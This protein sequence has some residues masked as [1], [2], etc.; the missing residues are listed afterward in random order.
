M[1]DSAEVLKEE[2]PLSIPKSFSFVPAKL[3]DNPALMAVNPDYLGS[4]LNLPLIERER[5]LAGNW[6]I[7]PAAGLVFNRSWFD[8]CDAVPAGGDCVRFWD[9]AASVKKLKGGDPDSTA[10]VRMRKVDGVFYIDDVVT[11]QEAPATAER[12]I[13]ARCVQD[14]NDC[15]YTGTRY[16]A[17]WE[18]E[19]SAGARYN[20]YH[21]T[22]VLAGIRTRGI[23]SREDKVSRAGA[24]STQAE[25]RN[26]KILK[27]PW[28]EQL[29]RELHQ[30]PDGAHDDVPDA[31]AG[32]F[33]EVNSIQPFRLNQY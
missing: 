19:P 22:T 29:L 30:F 17:A 15:K 20:S 27:A 6:K 4:M 5:L 16:Q 13:I 21:L 11:M 12:K 33:N 32:A 24:M 8:L 2:Y 7:R 18:I 23:T 31:C 26:I 1:A 25:V 28:T 3:E 9:L 10:G 14:D